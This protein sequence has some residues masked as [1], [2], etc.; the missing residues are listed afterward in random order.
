MNKLKNRQIWKAAEFGVAS[1]L[2]RRDITAVF[3]PEGT[4]ETDILAKHKD[5]KAISIQIKGSEADTQP[6]RWW[7]G[8]NIKVSDT[9]FY[10]F[11][12]VFAD[13]QQPLEFFIVPSKDAELLRKNTTVSLNGH[14]DYKDNLE[15]LLV[16]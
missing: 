15:A 6:R 2:W 10:I 9:H 11:V 13:L 8:E 12:N 7:T 1:E 4:P 5:Y 3:T 16:K 14:E